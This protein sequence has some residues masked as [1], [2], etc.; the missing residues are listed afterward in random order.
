MVRSMSPGLL[1]LEPI[2]LVKLSRVSRVIEARSAQ[3]G[4]RSEPVGSVHCA[5]RLGPAVAADRLVNVAR[6]LV[7]FG[8]GANR[9]TYM[10]PPVEFWPV[11]V[12]WGPRS[13]SMAPIS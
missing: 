6:Q 8:R 5:G 12:P 9:H 2:L 3:S 11:S 13:T 7:E 10:A 4:H 1:G